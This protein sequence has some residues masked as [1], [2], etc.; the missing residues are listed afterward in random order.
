MRLYESAWVELEGLETPL[1]VYKDFRNSAMFRVGD[2]QY[3][4]DGRPFNTTL[5][6]PKIKRLHTLQSAREAGLDTQY[7]KDIDARL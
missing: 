4:I 2:Y 7:R 3:D 5:G 6:V 1:R